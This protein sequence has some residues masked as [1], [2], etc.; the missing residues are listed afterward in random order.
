MPIYFSSAL[1]FNFTLRTSLV[2]YKIKID[3]FL[4]K[5]KRQQLQ[6]CWNDTNIPPPPKKKLCFAEILIKKKGR[7]RKWPITTHNGLSSKLND[8][9]INIIQIMSCRNLKRNDQ[10][11][12]LPGPLLCIFLRALVP[13]QP[14]LDPTNKIMP[15]KILWILWKFLVGNLIN[16]FPRHQGSILTTKN[17]RQFLCI[18]TENFS[19]QIIFVGRIKPWLARAKN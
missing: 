18:F 8:S 17:T 12:P 13:S 1:H 11:W 7:F 3:R 9:T 19:E 4:L 10:F 15:W 5:T 6:T 14:W 16:I 2:K